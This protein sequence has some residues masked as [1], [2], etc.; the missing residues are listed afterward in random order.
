MIA[1]IEKL[2]LESHVIVYVFR[3]V[4]KLRLFSNVQTLKIDVVLKA[5]LA[6]VIRIFSLNEAPLGLFKF[7]YYLPYLKINKFQYHNKK[8]LN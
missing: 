3:L 5:S 2:I 7:S 4:K 6:V 1:N 8:S